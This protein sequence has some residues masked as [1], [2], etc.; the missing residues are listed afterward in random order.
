MT[1][2][3]AFSIHAVAYWAARQAYEN[4]RVECQVPLS[5][6]DPRQSDYDSAYTPLVSAMHDA[7]VAAV[8]TPAATAAEMFKK[9]EILLNEELHHNDRDSVGELIECL[10]RDAARIGGRSEERRVGK[11]CVSTCRS[12]WSLYH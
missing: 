5:D 4:H 12:R 2:Q 11:E 1:A 10:G 3:T 7:A 9:I 6:D 8:H